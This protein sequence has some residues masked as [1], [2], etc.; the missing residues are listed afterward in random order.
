[1]PQHRQDLI[2]TCGCYSELLG[3]HCSG[4]SGEVP[5]FLLALA[6]EMELIF[7]GAV[8][9]PLEMLVGSF[10]EGFAWQ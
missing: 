7:A 8:F 2:E 9:G 5:K 3:D 1:L 6:G 10:S 4:Q